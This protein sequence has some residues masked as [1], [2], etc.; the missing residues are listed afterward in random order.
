MKPGPITMVRRATLQSRAMTSPVELALLLL[1]RLPL[2]GLHAF[3]AAA[4]WLL[5]R[6]P[7]RPRRLTRWHLRHCLPELDAPSRRRIERHSLCHMMKAAI[8]APAFWLGPR[9]RLDRWLAD[10]QAA[11]R[12]E[13]LRMQGRGVIWLCPHW[14][15]WELA[16][17]F[18]SA[19]GAMTT[20]YK[21]Q[22]GRLDALMCKGRSR[23][24]AR[25]VPT[26]SSGVKALLSALK[27]REMIGL[28]PDHDP[29][30]GAGRFAPLFGLTAHTTDLVSKLAARSGAPVWFCLAE[31]LPRGA[32]FRFHLLPAPDGIA[33]SEHGVAALNRGIEA[34]VRR[35]P[36]QYWWAYERYRR[37]PAGQPNPYRT[38]ETRRN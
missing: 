20:L 10:P 16:G 21:P 26:T 37:Q 3:A 31:R 24:G 11:A 13:A 19:H 1:S 6:L 12:L 25:L 17:L 23:L 33:D 7:N 15:A 4:G 34:I 29:P 36:D 9:A 14:G 18:C 8:E 28:L 32:G 27:R 30:P 5:A 2:R 38:S 22:K 35:W